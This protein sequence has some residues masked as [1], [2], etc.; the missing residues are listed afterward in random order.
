MK[1]RYGQGSIL[2]CRV[3]LFRQRVGPAHRAFTLLEL[4]IAVVMIS[5]LS[6]TAYTSYLDSTDEARLIAAAKDFRQI[7]EALRLYNED[8]FQSPYA[9]YDTS[10]LFGRYLTRSPVD[11]WLS[12]YIVDPFMGRII[13]RGPDG[14][15]QTE[16][17]GHPEAV[18]QQRFNDDLIEVYAPQGNLACTVGGSGRF[19]T[20]DEI[21]GSGEVIASID[22][23]SSTP[24]RGAVIIARSGGL[25]LATDVFSSPK[26]QQIHTAI[27]G[28]AGSLLEVSVSPGGQRFAGVTS[29]RDSLMVGSLLTNV[30]ETSTFKLMAADSG[31]TLSGASWN[32][33]GQ[34]LAV[35]TSQGE[36]WR[37]AVSQS[38]RPTRLTT[39]ASADVVRGAPSWS[40]DGKWI[41]FASKA[42]GEVLIIP[43]SG[44]RNLPDPINLTFA[45]SAIGPVALSPDGRKIAFVADEDL[46][47]AERSNLQLRLNVTRDMTDKVGGA[48]SLVWR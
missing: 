43:A 48:R 7:R 26:F 27:E 11:P 29:G 5:I 31:I 13:S 42:Q 8:H 38:A 24:D 16:I 12:E 45:G 33:N 28:A 9:L 37:L 30:K 20:L 15:L 23:F 10:A 36:I 35:S 34:D 6:L 18:D 19:Y 46:W 14:T 39:Q 1:Q 22:A 25:E 17:V 44:G 47:I 3:G 32:R 40:G 2:R 4:T 21:S 41:A